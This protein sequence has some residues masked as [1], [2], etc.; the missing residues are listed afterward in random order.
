MEVDHH[1]DA[2]EHRS[3]QEMRDAVGNA[4]TRIAWKRTVHIDAIQRRYPRSGAA[5]ALAQLRHQH[6]QSAKVIRIQTLAEAFHRDL[7]LVLVPMRSADH[8]HTG[9]IAGGATDYT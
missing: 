1:A 7:S 9:P 6:R 8:R 2:R 3:L 5:R 4:A